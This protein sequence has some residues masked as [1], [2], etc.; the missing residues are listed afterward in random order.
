[1]LTLENLQ[2]NM[3]V[4]YRISDNYNSSW[5]EWKVGRLH[6]ARRERDL[7]KNRR[8]PFSNWKMGQII[9]LCVGE[10]SEFSQR[11]FQE[12]NGCFNNGEGHKLEIQGL[13][14]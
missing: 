9:C 14:N 6:V 2:H 10:S 7:P 11:D 1:M 13:G 4:T 5:S 12:N 8:D 3:E